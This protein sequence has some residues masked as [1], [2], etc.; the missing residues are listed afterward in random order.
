VSG[1]S[2]TDSRGLGTSVP[3]SIAKAH[4]EQPLACGHSYSVTPVTPLSI[5]L[6]GDAARP[7][8]REAR[9]SLDE[10]GDV[11]EFA[12]AESAAVALSEGRPSPDVIVVAQ[13]F[14]G[15]FSHETIDRLRRLA[16]LARVLGLM[17]SWCEGE[18]RTGSPWPATVRTYWHQWP[19]RGNRQLRR[20][21]M[22]Q[23]CFWALPLTASDEERLL[24]DVA[25]PSFSPLYATASQKQCR[26][27]G[28]MPAPP[29]PSSGTLVL[30]RSHSREM[31]EWLSAACRSRGF[32]A[33]WQRDPVFA[34]VEG[35]A[36][37]LFDATDLCHH[38][39]DEL[40]RF[41][42]ALRPAPVIALLSFPRI[43]D[44]RR[45]VSAGA[46]VV[47]SKPLLLEDLLEAVG[48]LIAAKRAS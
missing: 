27:E 40:R 45:A 39:C 33:I 32:A 48:Q 18:T 7:D 31:G 19:T 17:G 13:A 42:D 9:T 47:L 24:V 11:V 21:A 38:E 5:L 15:Q 44:H 25:L 16:P 34:H 35:A 10:W 29:V 22:G 36:A 43:E 28:S 30:V 1:E 46:S 41:A 26:A 37:A 4:K 12:D 14:P 20:L 8:F 23:S 2:E 3:S 6:T